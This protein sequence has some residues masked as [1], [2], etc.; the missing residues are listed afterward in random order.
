MGCQPSLPPQPP[1]ATAAT[2]ATGVTTL[3]AAELNKR[4]RVACRSG[5]FEAALGALAAGAT[6]GSRPWICGLL[7]EAVSSGSLQLVTHLL[8]IGADVHCDL[9][10]FATAVAVASAELV[11]VLLDGGAVEAISGRLATTMWYHTFLNPAAVSEVVPVL[12]AEP[13]IDIDVREEW[14]RVRGRPNLAKLIG[15]E[16]SRGPL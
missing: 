11:R 8:T 14:R 3:S 2:G 10:F 16:A 13:T 7:E 1:I 4:L 12:L 6:L 5:D 9:E 15:D